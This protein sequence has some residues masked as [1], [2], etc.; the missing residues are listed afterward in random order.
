MKTKLII[1]AFIIAAFSFS[2]GTIKK[3]CDYQM[4]IVPRS[5]SYM[6]DPD[7]MNRA[8]EVIKKR[9]ISIYDIPQEDIMLDISETRLI[10]TLHNIDVSKVPQIKNVITLNSSLEFRETYENSEVIG[11]L[12]KADSLLYTMNFHGR[13]QDD[14]RKPNPDF[15]EKPAADSPSSYSPKQVTERNPLLS[16]LKPR[17]SAAGNPMPSCLVGLADVNDTSLVNRYLKMDK[18]RELFPD[19]LRFFW[20]ARPYKD[21]TSDVIY[22]LHAIKETTV[23][24]DAPLTGSSVISAETVAGTRKNNVKISLT[25]DPEGAKT[26]AD[27]TRKNI[28]RCIAVVYDGYVRSYPRVQAEISGGMT[29]ITGDFTPGEANELVN[30]FKSGQLPFELKIVDEQIIKME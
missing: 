23:N 7:G 24:G 17:L 16:I 9:L 3:D 1:L 11:Y 5:S 2:S 22:A 10:L 4:K 29:E 26:W 20:S 25:M 21:D 14:E 18:V 30:I 28:S 8:A 27:L 15:R 6:A 13:A 19:D 12:A